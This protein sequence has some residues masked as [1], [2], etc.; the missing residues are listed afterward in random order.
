VVSLGLDGRILSQGSVSDALE[1]NEKLAVKVA[2]DMDVKLKAKEEVDVTLPTGEIKQPDGKLVVAEEVA[3]GHVS[4][5]ASAS[6]LVP[7][8]V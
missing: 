4:W 1:K 3:E 2:K 5:A 7:T 6:I 8:H